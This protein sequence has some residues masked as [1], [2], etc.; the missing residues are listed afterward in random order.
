MTAQANGFYAAPLQ[1]HGHP[2]SIAHV[3]QGL[4]FPKKIIRIVG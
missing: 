4:Q 1:M 2:G 3:S